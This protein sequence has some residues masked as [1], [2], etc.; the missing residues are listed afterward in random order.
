M[1]GTPEIVFRYIGNTEVFQ[2]TS[3]SSVFMDAVMQQ[4]L[5]NVTETTPL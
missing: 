4:F 2:N 5:E 1:A 3:F